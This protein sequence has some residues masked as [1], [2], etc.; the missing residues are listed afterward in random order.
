MAK[1]KKNQK[2]K[3]T[4]VSSR[5]MKANIISEDMFW[6]KRGTHPQGTVAF[7]ENGKG[8][9]IT[10][11]GCGN[12]SYMNID[13]GSPGPTWNHVMGGKTVP[14]LSPSV[15]SNCCGWHG[16]LKNGEWVV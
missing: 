6:D 10:C 4:R 9:C 13:P 1:I 11:P 14:T 12:E 8:I 2:H 16:W 7:M 5:P 15:K 3:G